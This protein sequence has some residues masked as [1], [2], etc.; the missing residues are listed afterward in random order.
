[1]TEVTPFW[2][3]LARPKGTATASSPL[4][5]LA[6]CPEKLEALLEQVRPG[7]G[8]PTPWQRHLGQVQS[9]ECVLQGGAIF[10]CQNVGA[11]L[12]RVIG[13]NPKEC[14]VESSMVDCAHRH[15]VRND[16]LAAESVLPDMSCIQKRSMA[17]PAQGTL[18][19][20]G[21]EHSSSEHAL[22]H[23]STNLRNRILSAQCEIDGMG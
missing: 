20:V 16:W 13:S 4:A 21:G 1:M 5:A 19:R 2:A 15:A 10:F 14:V 6:C 12:D 8:W 11:D 7:P 22:V 3:S 9:L 17:E 18:R 23:S